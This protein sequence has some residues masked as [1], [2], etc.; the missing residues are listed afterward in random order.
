MQWRP[1]QKGLKNNMNDI[2]DLLRELLDRYSNTL[3]LDQEFERMR[4]EEEGF[5][6]EYA[7]WCEENGYM[8]NHQTPR[9]R[10]TAEVLYRYIM[11]DNEF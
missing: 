3:E 10:M 9:P 8:T 7:N 4:R 2:S 1:R 6:E 11:N 5:E